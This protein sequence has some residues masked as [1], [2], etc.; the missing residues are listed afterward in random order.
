MIYEDVANWWYHYYSK[1]E[2]TKINKPSP[3]HFA[4]SEKKVTP[5]FEK[6]IYDC[7]IC[8]PQIGATITPKKSIV[9]IKTTI[10]CSDPGE[11]CI[12]KTPYIVGYFRVAKI[13]K[14]RDVIHMDSSDSLLLLDNPI[15]LDSI[16]AKK[17]FPY[18]PKRY[19]D[20]PELFVRRVGSTLRNKQATPE[21]VRI[22]LTELVSRHK[23]GAANYLGKK[24]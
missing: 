21:E 16:F 18:K 2:D 8:H 1:G 9:L 23:L 10:G 22:V 20:C 3:S 11:N 13:D 17:L 12:S 24:I 14:E 7:G 5:D 15:I 6:L 4:L 19:W